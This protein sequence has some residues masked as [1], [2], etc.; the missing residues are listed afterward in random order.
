LPTPCANSQIATPPR[1]WNGS[2]NRVN[3]V[4]VTEIIEKARAK[5]V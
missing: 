3:T 5:E 4:V 2:A 1:A